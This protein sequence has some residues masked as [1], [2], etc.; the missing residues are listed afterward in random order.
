IA[1][2]LAALSRAAGALRE[3]LSPEHWRLV[4][5]MA[6][7]FAEPFRAAAQ[8]PTRLPSAA[9]VLP[10]LDALAV[11][12]AAVTGAQTDRVTRDHGWRLLAVGRHLERL[13]AA[14]VKLRT[15]LEGEALESSAGVDLL[16]ELFDSTITFRARYQ[17]HDDLLAITDLLVLDEANPRALAC[18][19]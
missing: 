6:E 18:V 15:L 10:V 4:R 11:Q 13:I 9:Q 12:L 8:E 14:S 2:N 19:L 3:R 1:F 16:L 17:R 7:L 5:G